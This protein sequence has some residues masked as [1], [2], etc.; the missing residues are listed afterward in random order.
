MRTDPCSQPGQGRCHI[1]LRATDGDGDRITFM[2][3]SGPSHGPLA[4]T[5]PDL[6]YTP[7]ASSAGTDSF[8]F[9]VTDGIQE[10]LPATV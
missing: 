5:A 2:V 7:D 3:V 4:G 10:S 8:I 9:K 1:V 6:T